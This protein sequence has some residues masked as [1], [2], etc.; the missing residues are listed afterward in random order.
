[1]KR[2]CIISGCNVLTALQV[3]LEEKDEKV[4]GKSK[5]IMSKENENERLRNQVDQLS[6]DLRSF[7]LNTVSFARSLKRCAMGKRKFKLSL[8]LGPRFLIEAS[9]WVLKN[10]EVKPCSPKNVNEIVER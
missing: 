8:N 1:M 6:K 2:I 7:C 4:N 3:K 5:E 9:T 10:S